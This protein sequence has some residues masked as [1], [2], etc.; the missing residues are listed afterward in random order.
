M[1]AEAGDP[2]HRA[3][4]AGSATDIVARVVDEQIERRLW[5]STA[6]E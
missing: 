2:H 4:L 5:Q 1:A 3:A 6:A